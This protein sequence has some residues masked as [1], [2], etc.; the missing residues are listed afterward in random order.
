MRHLVGFRVYPRKNKVKFLA[1]LCPCG[2]KY[3]PSDITIGNVDG[4]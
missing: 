3:R 2:G 1:E 4:V